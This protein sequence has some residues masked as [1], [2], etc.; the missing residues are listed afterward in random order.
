MYTLFLLCPVVH[1]KIRFYYKLNI[2]FL[3]GHT[4]NGSHHYI[5]KIA[6][7]PPIPRKQVFSPFVSHSA[8]TRASTQYAFSD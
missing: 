3:L 1:L 4:E 8:D 7:H 6:V 5:N 2:V